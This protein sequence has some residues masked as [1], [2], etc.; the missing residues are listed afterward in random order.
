MLLYSSYLCLIHCD[1]YYVGLILFLFLMIR[2][3]PRSTR[4]DTLFPYTTL[5]RSEDIL[6]PEFDA[7]FLVGSA[8]TEARVEQRI[9]V[10]RLLREQ[11]RPGVVVAGH[12]AIDIDE[13]G[14][15]AAADVGGPGDAAGRDQ[16]G[17]V[18]Q[19]VAGKK[20]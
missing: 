16:F 6:G 10:L 11:V 9:A 18:R 1:V 19:I 20:A 17:R 7:P 3:P 5:F 13:T 2:R 12:A 4:T 8:H 15:P 14:H